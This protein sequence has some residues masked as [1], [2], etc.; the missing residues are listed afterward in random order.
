MYVAYLH[1]IFFTWDE[2]AF[3]SHLFYGKCYVTIVIR[4]LSH[5]SNRYLGKF[6]RGEIIS[7]HFYS[8]KTLVFIFV[9]CP[10][11]FESIFFLRRFISLHFI[12]FCCQNDRFFGFCALLFFIVM[13]RHNRF[14]GKVVTFYYIP[15]G[16]SRTIVLVT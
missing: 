4:E 9:C 13:K 6:L 14:F 12:F 8:S 5:F 2:V 11:V 7:N 1:Y 15:A 16:C 10:F 3:M